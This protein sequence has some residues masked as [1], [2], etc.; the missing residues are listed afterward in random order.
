[1]TPKGHHSN[2]VSRIHRAALDLPESDRL[3]YVRREC[4]GDEAL[5]REVESLLAWNADLA[6]LIAALAGEAVALPVPTAST[7]LGPEEPIHH[8][9]SRGTGDQRLTAGTI[10]AGR[11]R[12]VAAIGRGGMGEVYRADDLELGQT[13]ALKFLTAFRGDATARDRLRAEVR[14]ARQIAHPNVCRV[15]DIGESDGRLY[16]TMEYV[17]GEDLAALLRRVGHL[18]SERTIEIGRKVAAGLAA[19]HARGI[20][21]RDLKPHNIMV[22]DEGEIRIMDFGIA[23][24]ASELRGPET[25]RGTPAYMAPEQLVG[26]DVSAQ[27]DIYALGLVLYELCTGKRPV[28]ASD[29]Q[30]LLRLR[31]SAP[32]VK[33]SALV[34]DVSPVLE[35]VILKCLDPDPRRRPASAQSVATELGGTP[36][37]KARTVVLAIGAV[38][39]AAALGVGYVGPSLFSPRPAAALTSRDPLVVADFENR[40]G[41][42]LFDGALKVALAVALEQSPFL[43]I[44]PEARARDTLRLM[45]RSAE[46]PITRAIARE[47]AQREG[48]KALLAGSISRLGSNYALALE[49]IDAASGDVLAREQVETAGKEQ[50]ITSLGTAASRLREKLGESLASIQK[51][52]TPLPR[53]TTASLDALQAYALALEQGRAVPRLEAIPHLKR[54][55]EL[56]PTFALAYAALSSVYANNGQTLLAPPFSRKAFE[57]RDRVSERERFFISWRYYSDAERSWDEALE[58]ARSWTESYPQEAFAFNSL[59]LARMRFGQFEQAI[60]AYTEARRLDPGL[61]VVY[62]NLGVVFRALDRRAEAQAALKVATDRQIYFGNVRPTLFALAF[63]DGNDASMERMVKEAGEAD[64]DS[65]LGGPARVLAYRGRVKAAREQFGRGIR[66]AEQR[67]LDQTAAVL[68]LQEAEI[69]AIA[70]ECREVSNAVAAG[71]KLTRGL[72]ELVRAS[73]TLALCGAARGATDLLNELLEQ[74]PQAYLSKRLHRPVVEALIALRRGEAARAIER[75][76]PVRPLDDAPEAERWPAYLRGLA[77]AQLKDWGRATSEFQRLVDHPGMNPMSP[78]HPLARLGLARAHAAAGRASEARAAY[79]TLFGIWKEA[80]PDLAALRDA[81]AEHARLQ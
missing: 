77:Y 24:V 11:F 18:G 8:A 61:S 79:E 78:L 80:D 2:D 17:S 32:P 5:Q 48:L 4:A 65:V 37:K 25:V 41:E 26:R 74:F 6:P 40:T 69:R 38:A 67:G 63:L 34:P 42:P 53:A 71:L 27:S 22:D 31:Q 66:S 15:Y 46:E 76:D 12:I 21:H 60:A 81:R 35:R 16:L 10:L 52:D 3:A 68:A 54:A 13:V 47:I 39:T 64:A 75:L 30:E 50:V 45:Q 73:R 59:G 43:S 72:D 23:V 56:D 51:F 19:A 70:G 9:V 57:L 1:M 7:T 62:G 44:Y 29:R 33:P 49:A 28:D 55:I 36:Q 58:L 14:V 20:V